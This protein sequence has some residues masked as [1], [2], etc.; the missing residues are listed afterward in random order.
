LEEPTGTRIDEFE[1]NLVEFVEFVFKAMNE[2][3]LAVLMDIIAMG[4]E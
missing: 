3:L 4:I 2:P 1:F